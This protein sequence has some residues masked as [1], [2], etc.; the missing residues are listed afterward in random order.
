MGLFTR[1]KEEKAD[2]GRDFKPPVAEKAEPPSNAP[3]DFGKRELE[4]PMIEADVREAFA[5]EFPMGKAIDEERFELPEQ[6]KFAEQSPLPLFVKISR[7]KEVLKTLEDLKSSIQAIKGAV[8][9]QNDVDAMAR[10]NRETI[11]SAIEK[12]NDKIMFIDNEFKRPEGF[13]ETFKEPEIGRQN[14][15][16]SVLDLREQINTVKNE[17]RMLT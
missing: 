13:K 16:Q 14:L 12:L 11:I 4:V 15:S 8:K 2:K 3:E 5:K 17:L 10:E 7:Y 9:V 6:L 1:R